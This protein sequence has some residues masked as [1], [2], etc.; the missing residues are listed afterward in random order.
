LLKDPALLHRLAQG[1]RVRSADF[2]I[3]RSARALEALYSEMLAPTRGP[4]P[5]ARATGNRTKQVPQQGA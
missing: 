1:A 4:V 5:S 2:N 3:A